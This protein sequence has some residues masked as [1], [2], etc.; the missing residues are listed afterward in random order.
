MK[1]N[2]IIRNVKSDLI[3]VKKESIKLN[4]ELRLIQLRDVFKNIIDLFCKAYQ[5][6]QEEYYIDKIIQ[7][8]KK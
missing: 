8:K 7:I 4:N 2:K 6:S 1:Y 5:I 3:A